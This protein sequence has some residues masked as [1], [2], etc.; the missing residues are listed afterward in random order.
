MIFKSSDLLNS[1][2]RNLQSL[3]ARFLAQFIEEGV[4]ILCEVSSG[5]LYF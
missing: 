4:N 1:S 5:I 2:I 3:T